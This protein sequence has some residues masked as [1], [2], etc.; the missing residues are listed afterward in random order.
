MIFVPL[1]PVSRH[2]VWE[3]IVYLTPVCWQKLISS[4]STF[5]QLS[6]GG[7][8][9]STCGVELTKWI[10]GPRGIYQTITANSDQWLNL[11][12]LHVKLL[13]INFASFYCILLKYYCHVQNDNKSL[14]S[15]PSFAIH[16]HNCRDMKIVI[17]NCHKF[18]PRY[19]LCNWQE[20][21]EEVGHSINVPNPPKKILQ[22]CFA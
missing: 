10:F 2:A 17:K 16:K 3:A 6:I 14:S 13:C 21:E 5:C 15:A 22:I 20:K 7:Y 19:D 18:L 9:F 1:S 11:K 4:L 12:M 8:N